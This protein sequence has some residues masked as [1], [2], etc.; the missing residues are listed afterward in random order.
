MIAIFGTKSNCSLI[1]AKSCIVCLT[2]SEQGFEE[3][4]RQVNAAKDAWQEKMEHAAPEQRLQL[5]ELLGEI[6][7]ADEQLERM[8]SSRANEHGDQG[9]IPK[10][11][12][13]A[14]PRISELTE[15]EPEQPQETSVESVLDI[16]S[17]VEMAR[18]AH[19]KED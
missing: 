7:S 11:S 13:R 8:R 2:M 10:A 4:E 1:E 16:K 17:L 5:I 12:F 14:H 15:P 18:K 3:F 19:K 9:I 6:A